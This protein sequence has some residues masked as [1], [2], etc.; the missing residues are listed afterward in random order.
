MESNAVWLFY[1]GIVAQAVFL[2]LDRFEARDVLKLLGCC[3]A[4]PLGLIP[5]KH[6]THYHLPFH[7]LMVA[8][9]FSVVYAVCF[10]KK[11]LEHIN[12]EILMVWT[13]VGLYIALR[14]PFVTAHPLVLIL[15]LVL[16]VLPI[17]NAF[18]EMDAS[19]AGRVY[20]YVW[21][22]CVL[23]GIAASKF[24]F[25]TAANVFG[26]S[27]G[28]EEI[29]SLEMFI[30]GMSFLYLVVNLWYVIELIPLPGKHQS[31]SDRLAEVREAME[32]LADDYD[33]KQ[34]RWW[35]TVLLLVVSGSLLAVNH[36]QQFVSDETLIPLLIIALPVMD[37]VKISAK[38]SS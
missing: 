28:T 29:N 25:S 10:K 16:S 9:V 21:F 36:F 19:H 37:K 26:F 27:H 4:A 6:E 15:L 24:A 35:K 18:T 12:K 32:I 8:C 2:L 14:T 1:A 30:I 17:V 5:G 38:A 31:F 34:V 22:L 23:V 3:A 7:L 11:I 13:L 33:A 20:F